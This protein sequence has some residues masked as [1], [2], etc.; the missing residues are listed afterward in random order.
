MIDYDTT[1]VAA[2][3]TSGLSVYYELFC[4]AAT[5][6]PC[7]TYMQ[8]NDAQ[9][10]TGTT[11]G[12]SKLNYAIKLW[13]DDLAVLQPYC[14]TIDSIMRALGFTRLSLNHLSAGTQIC[15]IMN[16]QGTAQEKIN[17]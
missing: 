12:Y 8:T 14:L 7:I 9:D 17:I 3:A 6:K 2:L 5:A 13:G 10:L 11:L 15:I 16:Y 1:L 4:D